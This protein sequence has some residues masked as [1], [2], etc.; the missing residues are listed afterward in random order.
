MKN[1]FIVNFAGYCYKCKHAEKKET[2]TP[3]DE[4]LDNPHSQESRR[5]MMFELE[6]DEKKWTLKSEKGK[7][8]D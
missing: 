4:C 3:C 2:E 6:P 1:N 5:P 7:R 8:R